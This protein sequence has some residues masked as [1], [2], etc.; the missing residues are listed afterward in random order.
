VAHEIGHVLQRH[1]ARGMTQQAQTNHAMTAALAGALLAALSGSA[2]LA[3]G[4]AA[5]GQAAA[6]DRQLGFSRQAEQE[7]DRSGLDM[8]I[9]AGYDP[10][11]MAR[12]FERLD[13][14]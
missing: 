6:V 2:D 3:M 8:T 11:G 7:A 12:M 5:F 10:A 13:S 4:V 9:R 14:A 1:I